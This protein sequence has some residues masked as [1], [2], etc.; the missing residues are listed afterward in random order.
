MDDYRRMIVTLERIYG[1]TDQMLF[2]LSKPMKESIA[3]VA[4]QY[5][6]SFAALIRLALMSYVDSIYPGFRTLYEKKL[7][8]SAYQ[9]KL[10]NKEMFEILMA[11]LN[12]EPKDEDQN[13]NK[14]DN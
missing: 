12:S 1:S 14:Q 11:Q 3:E 5:Q 13:L 10:I 4:F 6:T 2:R 9:D 8:S 7:F